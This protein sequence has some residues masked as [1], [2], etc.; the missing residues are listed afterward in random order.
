MDITDRITLFENTT[1]TLIVDDVIVAALFAEGS[2]LNFI[3]FCRE[4]SQCALHWIAEESGEHIRCGA[5]E[6]LLD[7]YNMKL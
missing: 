7:P 3:E 6:D 2:I 1:R 5:P 4:S